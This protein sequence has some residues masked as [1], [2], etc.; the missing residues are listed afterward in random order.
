MLRPPAGEWIALVGDTR[1][2][3][4]VGH[5]VSMATMSDAHGVFGV[6]STSQLVDVMDAVAP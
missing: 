3:P 2:G 6:T 1:F 5:G 4:A